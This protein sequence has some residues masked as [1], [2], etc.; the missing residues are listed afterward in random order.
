MKLIGTENEKIVLKE[1]G[2]RIKQYRI[3]SNITQKELADKCGISASTVVRIENGNDST[4]SN[5]L[6]IFSGLGLTQNIDIL[7]PEKQPDFKAIFEEKKLRQRAKS[8][9]YTAKTG[10]TWGEDE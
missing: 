9:S 7:I 6:K 1:L 3:S 4:F 5:Y 10:W 8:N 2:S